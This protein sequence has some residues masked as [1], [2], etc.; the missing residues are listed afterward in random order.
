MLLSYFQKVGLQEKSGTTWTIM[1]NAT[2]VEISTTGN[3]DPPVAALVEMVCNRDMTM[4]ETAAKAASDA[5][6]EVL[7]GWVV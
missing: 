6:I 4:G 5:L 1:T 2:A 3:G 7:T